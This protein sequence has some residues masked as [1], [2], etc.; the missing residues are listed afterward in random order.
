V[1]SKLANSSAKIF[2]KV[3]VDLEKEED[4]SL[5]RKSGPWESQLIRSYCNLCWGFYKISPWM[6]SRFK[7]GAMVLD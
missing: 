7:G 6:L 3:L 5:F 4:L 1:V 2:D